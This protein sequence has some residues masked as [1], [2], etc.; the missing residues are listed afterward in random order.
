MGV[1]YFSHHKKYVAEAADLE[2]LQKVAE[3]LDESFD[4]DNPY[5]AGPLWDAAVLIHDFLKRIIEVER[6]RREPS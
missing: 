5:L 4:P 1:R 6:A 2:E 3:E